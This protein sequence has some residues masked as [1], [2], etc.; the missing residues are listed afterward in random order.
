MTY[1]IAADTYLNFNFDARTL[2]T[3][4]LSCMTITVRDFANES[5]EGE[6]MTFCEWLETNEDAFT[7]YDGVRIAHDLIRHG[8]AKI[9]AGIGDDWRL[10]LTGVVA[11]EGETWNSE[12]VT[13]VA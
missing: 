1:T 3:F 5:D 10:T 2:Q 9:D 6:S 12:I 8:V 7:A 11:N 4:N 13:Q